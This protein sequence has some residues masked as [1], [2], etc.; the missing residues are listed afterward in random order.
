MRLCCEAVE[1]WLCGALRHAMCCLFEREE[2]EVVTCH[3]TY[4]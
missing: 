3:S 4:Q 2:V 1:V